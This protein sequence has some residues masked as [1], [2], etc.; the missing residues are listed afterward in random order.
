MKMYTNTN[1]IELTMS[2]IFSFDYVLS[3]MNCSWMELIED[4]DLTQL[5]RIYLFI[6][7]FVNKLLFDNLIS[8]Q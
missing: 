2:S 7:V 1:V 5:A 3:F 4:V 8:L 6:A